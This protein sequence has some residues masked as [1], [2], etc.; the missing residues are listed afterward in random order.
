MWKQ[1]CKED[2]S[3]N[4]LYLLYLSLVPSLSL[5]MREWQQEKLDDVERL[6]Q[7]FL[8]ITEFEGA[9]RS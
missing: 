3:F 8:H 7:H 5:L 4:P 9:M 6:G 1:T 2:V